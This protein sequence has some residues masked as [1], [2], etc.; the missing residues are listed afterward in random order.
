M[1]EKYTAER[2][3]KSN[4]SFSSFFPSRYLL[5]QCLCLSFTETYNARLASIGFSFSSSRH[6]WKLAF[7]SFS[8]SRVF[9]SFSRLLQTP[10]SKSNAV[11]LHNT[12]RERESVCTRAHT[13]TLL[14]FRQ[15]THI[16]IYI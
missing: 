8:F 1:E 3:K 16:Y 10:S 5:P 15:H 4:L 14:L 2:S 13:L 11:S 6:I 12:A 9:F 7:P